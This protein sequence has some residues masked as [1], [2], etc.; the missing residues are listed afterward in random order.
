MLWCSVKYKVLFFFKLQSQTNV[1]E[2]YDFLLAILMRERFVPPSPPL[3]GQ[4]K[5]RDLLATQW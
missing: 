1:E 2:L 4:N 5:V 3:C